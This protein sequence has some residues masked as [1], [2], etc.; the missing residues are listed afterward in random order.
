MTMTFG[1][2]QVLYVYQIVDSA[3]SLTFAVPQILKAGYYDE[4]PSGVS[5][6]NMAGSVW[7]V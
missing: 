4:P 5:T 3:S 1:T 2:L 7:Y 6:E